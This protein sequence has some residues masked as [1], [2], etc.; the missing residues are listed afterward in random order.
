MMLNLNHIHSSITIICFFKLFFR[1]FFKRY[2]FYLKILEV[3]NMSDFLKNL[4]N[5]HKKDSSDPKK[6]LDGHYYPPNE[7]RKAK[8]LTNQTR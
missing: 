6:N 2:P 7:R 4:R 8:D 1:L 3:T 5:S